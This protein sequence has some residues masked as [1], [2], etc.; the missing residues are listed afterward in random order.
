[1]GTVVPFLLFA[2]VAGTQ[3]LGPD[4]SGDPSVAADS[5]SV[6]ADSPSASASASG[7]ASPSSSASPSPTPTASPTPTPPPTPPPPGTTIEGLDVSKWQ[8]TVN[9]PQVAASGKR[10]IIMKATEGT[11]YVDPMFATN[12][13]GAKA[14]G[15]RVTAYHF[16]APDNTPG[17][18]IAEAD[19][20]VTVSNL[21][22]GDLTPALDI[23]VTGGLGPAALQAWVRAFVDE[24]T[25]QTAV[26][27]MIYVSPSFW[28][29]K[30]GNS[31]A[32]AAAGYKMLWIAHWGVSSPT[33][34]AQNWGGYGWT[35][36]QY[37]NCGHVTGSSGC[38]DLDRFNGLD[39]ETAA[40]HPRFRI[41]AS[42]AS[43]AVKQG[44]S[45][46]STIT[47]DRTNFSE[48]VT[49]SVTG[50][51]AGTTAVFT[52]N[53]QTG[54]TKSLL[55]MTSRV[56]TSTL[57]GSY[58]LAITGSGGGL[59]RSTYVTLVVGDGL[60]PVI[61]TPTSS[62]RAG[63]PLVG[64]TTPIRIAWSA[65]DQSGVASYKVQRQVNGGGWKT[66]KISKATSVAVSQA[67]TIGSKY[68]YRVMATDTKGNASGWTYGR[69][70]KPLLVQQS[71]SSVK[72][73]GSWHTVSMAGTSGGTVR[74][75]T[76]ATATTTYVFSGSGIA[77]VAYT[78]H[79]RGS[80][81]VY[82]DGVLV[83]TVNLRST[84]PV[85]KVLEF[86]ASWPSNGSHTLKVVVLGTAG[87]PRVDSDA[88]VKLR[89]Y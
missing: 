37:S 6:A 40:F 57:T 4:A 35:F 81:Q 87:H 23:E 55:T 3:A 12:Y 31:A 86:S 18:A 24:V 77:W 29:T 75:S 46:T 80:A 89:A 9:W 26:R 68:R 59:T 71:S 38:V 65:T 36:W 78:S 16:A 56:G 41:S 67:L 47:L 74:Y 1:M 85:T 61:T 76:A 11:G 84:K 73:H 52:P 25:L 2:S 50:L 27:P 21:A 79:S 32:F 58:P 15:L 5:P 44:Q 42:R 19:H 30:V 63:L 13:A 43:V 17:E 33:V 60:A 66:V 28:S 72:Y 64:S 70:F 7:S 22:D 48:A 69:T 39:L 88:F 82:L 10:F 51:P 62:L 14:A 53:P 20:F 49:L 45:V 34:P 83:K 8:G 54:A